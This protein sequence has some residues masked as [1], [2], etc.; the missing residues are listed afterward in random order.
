MVQTNLSMFLKEDTPPYGEKN[1]FVHHPYIRENTI[2]ERQYQL[3]IARHAL[4]KNTAVILPT[5][6]GKTIIAFLVM[7]DILP[8]RILLLAPT[9]P[10]VQQHYENCKKFLT[11]NENK[12]QMLA[13]NISAEKRTK[14]FNQAIIIVAT[15]QTIQN[16]LE[17]KRYTLKDFG[18]VIF[19]EMHHAVERYVF[20]TIAKHCSCRILGLTASP[21]SKKKKINKIL[22]NLKITHI[23]SRIRD[24]F[25]V[26][27][28]VKEILIDWIK[29]AMDTSLRT[30]QKPLHELYLEKLGKPQKL[31][32]LLATQSRKPILR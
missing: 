29:V 22:E 11:V 30:I 9:K 18:L 17:N 25:D 32:R 5:G 20:V 12:I 16:D 26:K 14:L 1:T 13:G 21:G 10:L 2:L 23:E 28:H 31:D 8:K 3:D 15:P 7:A 19:D 6:L 4:Q 24:D 27:D